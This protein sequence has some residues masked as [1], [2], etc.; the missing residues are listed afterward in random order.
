LERFDECFDQYLD[1]IKNSDDDYEDERQTNLAAVVASLSINGK[2][3]SIKSKPQIE[4][5]T[6]ELI[7]NKACALLG[8]HR[9]EEA[10]QKLNSAEGL[11]QMI[12]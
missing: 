3:E 1:L 5:Q 10:L 8:S 6:Y 11:H 9:Y 2:E 4:E 7:Y 12:I